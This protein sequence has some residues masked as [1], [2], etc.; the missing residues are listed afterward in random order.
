MTNVGKLKIFLGYAAGVGKTY[1]MLEEAQELRHRGVDVV[2]GYFEPHGR[3]D[4]IA[5]T[6][7]LEMIPRKKITYRGSTFEEMDTEKIIERHPKVTVVDEFPH[8]NVP[9]STRDKRWEDALFIL[10]QGIDV[11]TTMNVQHLE[12]LNDQMIQITGIKV[13]ETIPDWVVKQ[14]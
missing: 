11:L 13:R 14:A 9:G 4:T 6:E 3:K 10:D 8:T 12:S 5:K 2:I 1:Q 7:G